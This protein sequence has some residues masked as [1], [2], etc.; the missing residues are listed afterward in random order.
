MR[1]WSKSIWRVAEVE[2]TVSRLITAI[3][4]L[5]NG[6]VRVSCTS[7]SLSNVVKGRMFIGHLRDFKLVIRQGPLDN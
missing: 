2:R 3:N 5:S 1:S 4:A 6:P 7:P